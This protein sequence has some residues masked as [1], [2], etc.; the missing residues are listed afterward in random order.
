MLTST[1]LAPDG[2]PFNLA[3]L[4]NAQGM[5]VRFMDWGA[6]WISA[7][8]PQA[9]G[10]LREAILS[11][12]SPER[13]LQQSAYLGATVGRYANRIR[14]AYL[15]SL[16][17]QLTSNQGPHQLHGGPEGFSHRRWQQVVHTDKTL[18]YRLHSADGDQGF[19]GNLDIELTLTL[20]DD[21]R[22]DF[23][24]SAQSDALTPLSLTNHAYFNLDGTQ[25]DIRAHRLTLHGSS[26][27]PVDADG[28]PDGD[29]LPVAETAFDFR[30][31]KSL[32]QDFLAD[33]FQ[34]ITGGYDHAFIIDTH[35]LDQPVAT[36][37]AAD[38]RLQMNLFS[39]EPA[40]QLY[41][42][43]YLSGTPAPEGE[44]DNY[45][46]VALEPGYRP[47]AAN[48]TPL[49]GCWLTAGEIRQIRFGYHFISA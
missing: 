24:F 17:C 38:G 48:D 6:T 21:N 26:F 1:A 4:R 40:L 12:G 30:S 39:S 47:D 29:C 8:I 42:G 35:T 22:L 49:A 43:N 16:D 2:Q 32:A 13:Y 23:C 14:Q 28:L 11:C 36:L 3:E 7:Q 34:Q 5:V 10:H 9:D 46:G 18:V 19:P 25:G 33:N 31:P 45:Q 20:S 44:Y 37:T 41:T 15:T 27:Q